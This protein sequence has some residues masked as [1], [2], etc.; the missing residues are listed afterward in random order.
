MTRDPTPNELM[1]ANIAEVVLRTKRDFEKHGTNPLFTKL[2]SNSMAPR[3][4]LEENNLLMFPSM[5]K[6]NPKITLKLIDDI[7]M[8]RRV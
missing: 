7:V 1:N 6:G 3:K 8:P 4:K 5:A 2:R